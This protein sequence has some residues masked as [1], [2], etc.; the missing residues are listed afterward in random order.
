MGPEQGPFVPFV[1][2]NTQTGVDIPCRF[3]PEHPDRM[4]ADIEPL[5]GD[6][7]EMQTRTI[8]AQSTDPMGLFLW[9]SSAQWR[10]QV[11]AD[12][13]GG[14]N[15][16]NPMG[17][18]PVQQD[19]TVASQE[20]IFSQFNS[21]GAVPEPGNPYT[22]ASPN[23]YGSVVNPGNPNPATPPNPHFAM[24]TPQPTPTGTPNF[25]KEELAAEV[26]LNQYRSALELFDIMLQRHLPDE[27]TDYE[28]VQRMKQRLDIVNVEYGMPPIWSE[29]AVAAPEAD[30]VEEGVTV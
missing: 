10:A 12:G 23:P 5:N 19:Q 26:A 17:T 1:V 22:G 11:L 25:T 7:R 15:V 13:N 9:N 27:N 29:P 30:P 28:V 8:T 20:E 2:R 24:P 4:Y 6:A 16:S 21:P 3:N 18:P 14:A